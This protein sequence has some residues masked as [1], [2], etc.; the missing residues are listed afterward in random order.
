MKL[1]SASDSAALMA[2]LGVHVVC[3]WCGSERSDWLE[4]GEVW[5]E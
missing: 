1:Y 4:W 5:C 2:I 3:S